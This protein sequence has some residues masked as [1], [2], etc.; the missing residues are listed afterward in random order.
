MKQSNSGEEQPT[1]C[2]PAEKPDTT[3]AAAALAGFD[4]QVDVSVLA[5]IRLMLISKSATRITL[6]PANQD[7]LEADLVPHQP[8]RVEPHANLTTG[9][10]LIIQVKRDSG[11]P[12]NIGDF[13]ALLNHGEKRKPAKTHL[14][15][16]KVHYLLVTNA[17]TKGVAMELEVGG[18]E[19]T[20]DKDKFP[21]SLIGTLSADAAGRVAIWS[22]LTEE[23]LRLKLREL[24]TDLLHVPGVRQDDLLTAL[25]AEANQRMRS[26][27]PGIWRRE[28]LLATV[29]RHG[30]HLASSPNLEAFVPPSNFDSM[31]E[32]F[33]AKNAIVIKGPSGTGKTEA[34]RMLCELARRRNGALELVVVQ[35]SDAPASTR[36]LDDTGPTLFYIEDPWGQYSLLGGHEAWT[37]QL[38]RLLRDYAG[39]D[40]QYVITTRTDVLRDADSGDGLKQWWAELDSDDYKDGQLG[41]IYD[42]RST[43][44]QADMQEKALA[45]RTEALEVFKTP[46]QVAL[47]FANLAQGPDAGEADHAFLR[48]LLRLADREAVVGEVTRYL[49]ALDG[50]GLAAVIWAMISPRG[51]FD[52]NQLVAVRRALRRVDPRLGDG[53]EALVDRLVAANHLRQPDQSV[54]FAHPSVR[55][56]FEAFIKRDWPRSEDAIGTLVRALTELTGDHRNWGLETAALILQTTKILSRQIPELDPPFDVDQASHDAI[57]AWLDAG[58]MRPESVFQTLLQ[59]ASD[60][61][62]EAS[63]PSEVARWL[64]TGVKRGGQVFLDSWK[65]PFFE[66]AWYKRVSADPR[67]R[68]IAD[69]FVR[70]ALPFE[71]ATYGARFAVALDRLATGLTPAFIAAANVMVGGGFDGNVQAVANGAVRDLP[72]Y[73]PVLDGALNDLASVHRKHSTVG[74][75]QWLAIDDGELDADAEEYYRDAHEDDGYASGVFVDAFVGAKRAAGEWRD[76]RDHPRARELL[77]AW[78]RDVANSPTPADEEEVRAL[79]VLARDLDAEHC[80]WHALREQ[81]RPGFDALLK[82]R[83]LSH[84][85]EPQLRSELAYCALVQSPDTLVAALSALNDP[86]RLVTL[87]VDIQQALHRIAS[88]SRERYLGRVTAKL[89]APLPEIVAALPTKRPSATCVSAAARGLLETAAGRARPDILNAIVPVIIASGGKP[90]SAIRRW[91]DE[92]EDKDLAVAAVESAIAIDDEATIEHALGHVRAEAR[93]TALLALADKLPDAL[94]PVVLALATNK[95][96]KVR[97]AMVDILSKRPSPLHQQLLLELSDDRWSDADARYDEPESNPIAREAVEALDAYPGLTDAVGERL[98]ALADTTRDRFLSSIALIIASTKCGPAIRE[99]IWAIVCRPVARW[100]RVDALEALAD[101][102]EVEAAIV[103]QATPELIMAMPPVIAIQAVKLVA[104]HAQ[105][106]EAVRALETIGSANP[107]RG[108]LLVGALALHSRDTAA[109]SHI[110]GLFGPEHPAAG[111][112]SSAD[113]LPPHALDDLGSPRLRKQLREYLGDRIVAAKTGED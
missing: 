36:K 38:P 100:I 74:V 80:A 39:P 42:Q 8:G 10:R 75:K 102:S 91:L 60:V 111:L 106:S 41:R 46:L 15:D 81:W 63:V 9:Y 110:L 37:E 99:K 70:E 71:R 56:G 54:A 33:E 57:D 59:L 51:Q 92:T 95:G 50:C 69:R 109:A 29:R 66:D 11:E 16:T 52:R 20:A 44:L 2:T 88:K 43:L 85:T 58:L 4:Y 34:A 108:L 84:P 13:E 24:M 97:R 82:E 6:E 77:A 49:K 18:F 28:D 107:H 40:H 72:T 53:L 112:L 93:R 76:L 86:T 32:H 101:S 7:D 30:G 48:R 45:F 31:C 55:E 78:A 27:I 12:W 64:L 96:S 47:Y 79:V 3:G 19:E 17:A 113:P 83:L 25:R 62:T 22:G 89:P 103:D 90:G 104:Q 87:L 61:G 68:Q 26:G 35:P 21:P 73:G 1:T 94:P 105:M 65:P 23:L 67:T 5:A 14:K 98:L